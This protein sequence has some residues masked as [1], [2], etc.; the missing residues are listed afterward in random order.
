MVSEI[1]KVEIIFGR[2]QRS[3]DDHQKGGWSGMEEK[4]IKMERSSN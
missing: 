1:G 2:W 4:S 3:R